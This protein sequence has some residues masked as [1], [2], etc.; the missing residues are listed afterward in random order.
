MQDLVRGILHARVLPYPARLDWLW[1]MEGARLRLSQASSSQ[2]VTGLYGTIHQPANQ[3]I[4]LLCN[5]LRIQHYAF[6][7]VM[8]EINFFIAE[9]LVMLYFKP[10]RILTVTAAHMAAIITAIM[11]FFVLSLKLISSYVHDGREV[12]MASLGGT[13]HHE[14]LENGTGST[15]DTDDSALRNRPVWEAKVIIAAEHWRSRAH[16][17]KRA[18]R[19]T[20][21]GFIWFFF[22]ICMFVSA[23]ARPMCCIE[24]LP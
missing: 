7:I 21:R 22:G 20:V 19:A 9:D 10:E 1:Q 14:G 13:F 2:S 17:D 24:A 8:G 18:R 5:R 6:L 16:L 12:D 15:Q 11:P 3:A 4:C 23:T